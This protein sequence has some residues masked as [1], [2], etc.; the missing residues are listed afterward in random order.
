MDSGLMDVI[1]IANTGKIITVNCETLHGN[2]VTGR[3]ASTQPTWLDEEHHVGYNLP[4]VYMRYDG[5][6]EDNGNKS[7][8]VRMC[9]LGD[10]LGTAEAVRHNR[11]VGITQVHKPNNE[12]LARGTQNEMAGLIIRG[13][14]KIGTEDANTL[15]QAAWKQLVPKQGGLGTQSTGITK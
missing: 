11:A 15:A 2:T 14:E 4:V 8:F 12:Q 13:V 5:T 6:K 3:E 9:R 7:H 10:P 1:P